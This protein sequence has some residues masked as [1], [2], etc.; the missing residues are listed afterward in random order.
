MTTAIS[1]MSSSTT[2]SPRPEPSARIA[3]SVVVVVGGTVVVVVGARVV[4]VVGARVVVAPLDV[5]VSSG[6]VVVD[7]EVSVV[8]VVAP[9]AASSSSVGVKAAAM[10]KTPSTMSAHI[11]HFLYQGFLAGVGSS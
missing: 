11:H 8:D 2:S 4:V 5:V 6:V 7:S 10:T 9:D 3:G 1:G